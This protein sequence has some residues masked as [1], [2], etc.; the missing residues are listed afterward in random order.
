MKPFSLIYALNDKNSKFLSRAAE[1][2][3]DIIEEFI[4]DERYYFRNSEL[5]MKNW[6]KSLSC[7]CSSNTKFLSK[8]EKKVSSLVAR[9]KSA[10]NLYVRIMRVLEPVKHRDTLFEHTCLITFCW[11][12]VGMTSKK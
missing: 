12:Y 5:G 8:I 7:R 4:L 10:E 3:K 6:N 2:M 11:L 1:K 9:R